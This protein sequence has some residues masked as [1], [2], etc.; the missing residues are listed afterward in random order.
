MDELDENISCVPVFLSFHRSLLFSGYLLCPCRQRCLLYTS[1]YYVTI[2]LEGPAKLSEKSA[3]YFVLT[4]TDSIFTFTGQF[5]PQVSA[6][7]ILTFTEV[8]QASSG[9]WKN[10]WT[11]VSYTHLLKPAL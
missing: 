2:S 11:P 10:Y 7:P 9:H 3:N 5:T 6:S 1:T 4:P 8:Q